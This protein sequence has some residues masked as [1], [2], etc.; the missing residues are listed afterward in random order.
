M[1]WRYDGHVSMTPRRGAV[2]VAG[3][4]ASGLMTAVSTAYAASLDRV[5][6]PF[7]A[8]ALRSLVASVYQ[9]EVRVA[10]A[11]DIDE[12][13]DLDVVASTS[14]GLVVFVNDGSGLFDAQSPRGGS[15]TRGEE[16]A[17]SWSGGDIHCP[18]SIQTDGP[19]APLVTAEAHLPPQEASRH[20]DQ[21]RD[22]ASLGRDF[23][24]CAPRAPPSPFV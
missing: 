10:V 1:I 24:F 16:P 12:D 4:L 15:T 11:T 20:L 9:L 6:D 5:G 7:D 14:S 21:N 8:A 17:T 2:I 23:G 19:S 22:R 3:L 18:E 13:G